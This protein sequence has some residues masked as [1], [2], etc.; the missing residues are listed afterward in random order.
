MIAYA[1][2]GSNEVDNANEQV[3]YFDMAVQP[4]LRTTC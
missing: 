2:L 4:N 3:P 1:Y